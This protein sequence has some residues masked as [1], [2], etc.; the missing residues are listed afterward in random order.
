MIA[1]AR[2][3]DEIVAEL[4]RWLAEQPA[5]STGAPARAR[6]TGFR[7]TAGALA[8]A[9]V[10][11]R[12]G[13]P[14]IVLAPDG[15]AAEALLNDLRFLTGESAATP[16]IDRRVHHF[17]GWDVPSFDEVSPAREVTAARA[18]GLFHLVHTPGVILVTTPDALLQR[19]MPR[20]AAA[21]AW[22]YLG[23]G[24]K[25]QLED[26]TSHLASW[27]YHRVPAVQDLGE[28]AVR[29]GIL[30]VFPGGHAGPV[31][32]EFLG[33]AIEDM[34]D[35]DPGTQ[36]S[37][38]GRG[39]LLLLPVQ[40]YETARLS[41]PETLRAVEE[42]AADIGLARR[43]RHRWAEAL[44]AGFHLP[45][46][47]FLLP[48][49]YRDLDPITAY[50]PEKAIWW[51]VD[52]AAVL[53]AARAFR[54]DVEQ[55]ATQMGDGALPGPPPDALYLRPDDLNAMFGAGPLVEVE[56]LEAPDP[57][58]PVAHWRLASRTNQGL[59]AVRTGRE[60]QPTL[61][62]LA[63]RLREW[64]DGLQG[65][66]AVMGSQAQAARFQQLMAAHGVAFRLDDGGF[67][68]ARDWCRD[69]VV[70]GGRGAP[71]ED[72]VV[73]CGELSAGVQLPQDGLVVLTEAE[74]F[75]ERRIVRR[76][77]RASTTA[78]LTSLAEL[79]PEDY[80]VHLDHGI[81]IYRGLRHLKVAG[82]EGDYLHVEYAGGDRLYLPVDRINLVQRYVGSD[83]KAPA[84]DKL[85][86]TSWER[87]K[88][89]AHDSIL[90][91][92][93]ELL[94]VEAAREVMET[95]MTSPPDAYFREFEAR[96]P[97]DATPDQRAAVE[98]VLADMQRPKPMD[99]LVCGDV[100]YGKTEV[101]MRAAF[102]AVMD[103]SQVAVLVP[104]TVLAQ[105]HVATFRE[106]FAG[107]PVRIEMLSRFRSPRENRATVEA[108]AS[109][110]VDLVI[111]THRLLQ[112]DV[113]FRKLGLL[114][115]DEEHRFGVADKERI[116]RLRTEVDV[117]TL[118][119]TPIPRTLQ[120]S[121]SG[122]RDLSV[123]ETPPLDRLAVRTYVARFDEHV[124]RDAILRE[125][126]RGGQ[127]FFVHN[128]VETI[129][130]VAGWVAGIVPEARV[131]IGHGQMRERQLENV[132][133]DFLSG[134][135]TVLVCSAI[136]ESGLDIPR[137]N[138]I[139]INRADTFGLAQ[140]YQLRGRVG[141][142]H[143]RAYA[144]LL[145]P[146]EHLISRDAHKRLQVLQELDDLGSGFRLAAHDLEI[147]GAGNLLGKQQSGQIAAIG[148][149]LYMRM[150]EDV[151]LELRG[152][153]RTVEV[154]PEVQLGVP[155]FIPEEYVPDVSQR[156]VLYKRLASVRRGDEIGDLAEEIQDRYGPRPAPVDALLQVM[157]FRRY[158]KDVLV[159]RVRRRG[160]QLLF[161]F[162]PETP[163]E[164]AR[165][166]EV[167]DGA[168]RRCRMLGEYQ[169]SFSPL[170]RDL[171]GMLDESR[172]L[173]RRL[174]T[175]GQSGARAA[176]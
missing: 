92:A 109:G 125:L 74:V 122:I 119:A 137:A 14:F 54:E 13:R 29:G 114:V 152:A 120:M 118:T 59:A 148:L 17:P 151:I 91:M 39:D 5:S 57:R 123:I 44:E 117:L 143:H 83:A 147:R 175:A 82:T 139:I 49:V 21:R 149:E 2:S 41:L 12:L 89:K 168:A 132:M 158:L 104:T 162:H 7:G 129:D 145:I 73:V 99:R 157:D 85:G 9:D 163:V 101:A 60:R 69:H 36:R 116:K 27:G 81:G 52:R 66:V 8:L 135:S 80:V 150:L 156:L 96:F 64:R 78:F 19:V 32:L 63:A 107:Y 124:V 138:T 161:D 154:E 115:V 171:D 160:D 23:R 75:G 108:I 113:Q 62:P 50:L 25:Q 88:K 38:G 28:F 98:D 140:L 127:V 68:A 31:R 79:K 47:E 71:A 131:A 166:L 84:L 67:A 1:D 58:E 56:P 16:P 95:R 164:G 43:E 90:S 165:F 45:G 61:A 6:L 35:F 37:G 173:L 20:Q 103:G 134:A 106:R 94:D 15:E 176:T 24:E 141:R 46:V 97:Y 26:V 93:R 146:G 174:A 133:R 153:R 136:I 105:Q 77:R 22:R 126:R 48:Y 33:D 30:D 111:G 144:Y 40:E 76:A 130:R 10:S 112:R 102:L 110:A 169:L 172:E 142:S 65:L 11:A 3:L 87:I 170:A 34:R 70:R 159:T 42:R 121:L 128:R 100:G 53:D 72:G 4:G 167:V 51:L 18:A 86:G 155:A 55:R